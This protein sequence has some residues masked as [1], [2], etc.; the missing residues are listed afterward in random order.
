VRV[1]ELGGRAFGA[2]K[3]TAANFLTPVGRKI[4]LAYSI[5]IHAVLFVYEMEKMGGGGN[6]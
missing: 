3:K 2:R 6:M 4:G 1:L 5:K